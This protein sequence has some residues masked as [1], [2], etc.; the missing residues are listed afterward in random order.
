MEVLSARRLFKSPDHD[1]TTNGE[2]QS[3]GRRHE[4][5]ADP[6]MVDLDGINKSPAP[7]PI[8]ESPLAPR[9]TIRRHPVDVSSPATS[10][11]R[12]GPHSRFRAHQRSSQ[13]FSSTPVPGTSFHPDSLHKQNH[14][15]A[16]DIWPF[17]EE[18]DER[19]YICKLCK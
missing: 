3:S 18:V 13:G 1:G 19:H 10:I 8:A 4:H 16:D 2:V 5:Q 12:S 17:Y 14:F 11:P 9:S 6:L 7:S 15:H